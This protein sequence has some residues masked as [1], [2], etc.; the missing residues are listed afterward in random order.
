MEYVTLNG[1]GELE[2]VGEEYM[3]R[4]ANLGD[5]VGYRESL[6][7]DLK[8][9]RRLESLIVYYGEDWVGVYKILHQILE[10]F[11][12][13]IPA[14][15]QWLDS[16]KSCGTWQEDCYNNLMENTR[17]ALELR[18][19]WQYLPADVKTYFEEL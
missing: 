14:A 12:S 17:R 4:P 15:Q 9:T 3:T 13:R 10:N 8:N 16:P 18:E 2:W 1:D 5:L 19:Q 11:E 7:E 6:E